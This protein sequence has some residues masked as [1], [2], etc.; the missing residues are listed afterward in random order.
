MIFKD[1]DRIDGLERVKPP[2]T[3]TIREP[4]L[5]QGVALGGL[6]IMIGMLIVMIL[7]KL[8]TAL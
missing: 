7:M 2:P 8:W 4:L 5:R 6:V 3:R 1:G